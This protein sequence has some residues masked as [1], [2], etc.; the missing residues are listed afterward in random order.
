MAVA[1]QHAHAVLGFD[2]I[3]EPLLENRLIRLDSQGGNAAA[4]LLRRDRS[5]YM[6]IPADCRKPKWV[7]PW[8][9]VWYID[10]C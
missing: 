3:V 5:E 8:D 9:P 10:V 6:V 4:R 1:D 2:E 7:D